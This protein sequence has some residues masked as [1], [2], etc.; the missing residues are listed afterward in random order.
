MLT[1]AGFKSVYATGE[2][3]PSEFFLDALINSSTLDLGLGYFSSSGFRALAI[4]FAF[5][6]K[7]GGKMRIIIND[8]LSEEDK[9]AITQ[10]LE[11]SNP[12]T[13]IEKSIVNNIVSL[14]ETLSRKDIH[15]FKCLSWLIATKRLELK[16]TIPKKNKIGIVHQKFGVFKDIASNSLAFTGSINFSANALFN[17]VEALCCDFSWLN[18]SLSDERIKYF[19]FLFN[20]T[21]SGLSEVVQI[22]PI[23]NVKTIIKESFPVENLKELVDEELDLIKEEILRD[24]MPKSYLKKVDKLASKLLPTTLRVSTSED[25]PPIREYQEEAIRNWKANEY[26]GILEMATGTGKT[27]TALSAIWELFK[28]KNRLFIIISCPFIHLA[29]QWKEE[30]KKFNLDG[31]LVGES[32]LLWE[33][34]TA[35]QAQLF[36]KGK[37]NQVV[38]IT[39]NASFSSVSF[40]RIVSP[41]LPEALLIIDEVHYAGASSIRRLLPETCKYRLGLS[42]TPERYGDEEGTEALFDYFGSVVYSFP[43]DQAIGTFLTPYYYHAVPVEL[44]DEEFAEYCDLTNQIIRLSHRD[45]DE[46]KDRLDK[47]LIRR[48]RVQNNSSNKLDWIR[49]NIPTL[50]LDYSLFYAGDQIFNSVKQLLGRDLK[51]KI[52]EF[53]SRQSRAERRKLLDDFSKQQIQS[54]IA[55]KCLDEGVDVPPTRVAYFLASSSNPREF[56]QRR[57]RVLRKYP[58][59]EYA[60]IYDLI[61]IPPLKFIEEGRNGNEYHAVKSA[62]SKEYKRVQEFSSMAI[63]QF[64]SINELFA[65]ASQLDLLDITKD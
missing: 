30:A 53:T 44:S 1:E 5:F 48:A 16:A 39:T 12:D 27:Y 55:M 34:D 43:I 8:I 54:L 22:I 36:I 35:R 46:S 20:K 21:W 26:R 6:I 65:M 28:E 9:S 10:G 56:V 14:K 31:I 15:F 23:E 2:Q 19:E 64:N 59:K 42:A 24:Q 13:L 37:I 50:P 52:H 57:G 60:T 49:K 51:I 41:C 33:E 63:N 3:E 17:N 38:L 58:G 29:E 18:N 4:G 32:K 7:R 47:L 11:T 45:D 25:L 61:S 62:F 40:Q